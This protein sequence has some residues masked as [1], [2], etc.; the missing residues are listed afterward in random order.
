LWE[1]QAIAVYLVEQYA[2]TDSLYPKDLELRAKINQMMYFN[3]GTLF[4]RF[5]DYFHPQAI[6]QK[7]ADPVAFESLKEAVQLLDKLIAGKRYAC[8]EYLTVA[9]FSLLA[10]ISTLEATGFD[11]TGY[12]NV[13]EWYN[14][15][16][17]TAPGFVRNQEGADRVK[18]LTKQ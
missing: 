18:N 11:L 14:R 2:K 15:C 6:A 8:T 10:T 3:E 12:Q 16:K 1:S 5:Y 9:D 7:P 17:A 13:M 4:K